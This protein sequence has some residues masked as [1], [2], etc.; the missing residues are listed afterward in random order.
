MAR[1]RREWKSS[2]RAEFE[3]EAVGRK[4]DLSDGFA[5]ACGDVRE[6][7]AECLNA[8]RTRRARRIVRGDWPQI[9]LK[10]KFYG[11]S[12]SERDGPAG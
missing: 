11:I 4:V 2:G 12:E 6:K 5:G 10:R 7:R 8:F 9:E 1:L 3:L